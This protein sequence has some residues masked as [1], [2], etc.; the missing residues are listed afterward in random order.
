VTEIVVIGVKNSPSLPV[1]SPP[2]EF[3]TGGVKA[4]MSACA[5]PNIPLDKPT[6]HKPAAHELK[7][8]FFML[9]F[10]L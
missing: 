9:F 4:M 7:R 5:T 2:N 3:R 8:I 1:G 10:C 6:A